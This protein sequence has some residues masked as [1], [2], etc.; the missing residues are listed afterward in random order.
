MVGSFIVLSDNKVVTTIFCLNG[1]N[2]YSILLSGNSVKYYIKKVK[3][4]SFLIFEEMIG[5][6]VSLS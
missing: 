4:A 2:G 5:G 1:F 3:A 6:N